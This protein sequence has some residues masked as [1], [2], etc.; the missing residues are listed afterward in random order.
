MTTRLERGE[1]RDWVGLSKLLLF[2]LMLV[3]LACL[4]WAGLNNHLGPDPAKELVDEAGLWA[5]R[6]LLLC[7]AMT[8]LRRISGYSFW[9]RYRR[10][11]GLFALLYALIHLSSYV[12]L[13]FGARWSELAVELTRRPYIIIGSLALLLM[14]PLGFTSTRWAQRRLKYRWI[15]LHR[16]IYPLSLLALLHFMWVKKL[17]LYAVWPYGLVLF[18][19][20]GLRLLWFFRQSIRKTSING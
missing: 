17:G 20:L 18:L 14:L 13:L 7:L 19:L 9:G 4:L 3:P 12:F 11:L 1:A 6:C 15:Q 8:P 10:M 2:P 16:L 5:I